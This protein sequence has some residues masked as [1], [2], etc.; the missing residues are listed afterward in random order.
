[1]DFVSSRGKK[2]I[3]VAFH[4][5]LLFM[6][7]I[8]DGLSLFSEEQVRHH[9]ECDCVWGVVNEYNAFFLTKHIPQSVCVCHSHTLTR[10]LSS[11][12]ILLM[13]QQTALRP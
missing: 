7:V 4:V 13:R 9:D 5:L 8:T 1:M 2:T 10:A 6:F 3:G 12:G 11:S